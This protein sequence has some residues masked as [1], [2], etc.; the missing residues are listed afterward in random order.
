M[1]EKQIS[2]KIDEELAFKLK[3]KALKERTTQKELIIK[4]LKEKLE[5]N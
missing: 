1:A 4:W 2:V 3:E 5:N